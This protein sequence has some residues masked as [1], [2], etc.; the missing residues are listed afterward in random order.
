[1]PKRRSPIVA[2]ALDDW[3]TVRSAGRG[4]S[5]NTLRAYRSDIAAVAEEILGDAGDN[6]V[7]AVHQVRV[8]ELTPEAVVGPSRR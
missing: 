8:D 7:P 4:L 6:D 1:V 5:A 2:E 3:L